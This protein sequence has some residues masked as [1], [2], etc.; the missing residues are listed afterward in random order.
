MFILVIQFS[1]CH[2]QAL[3]WKYFIFYCSFLIVRCT[4]VIERTL[5]KSFVPSHYQWYFTYFRTSFL[6]VKCYQKCFFKL[7]DKNKFKTSGLR[8]TRATRR[9][10]SSIRTSSPPTDSQSTGSTRI[11]TGKKARSFLTKHTYVNR[12]RDLWNVMTI[13][14]W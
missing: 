2:F 11:S 5:K 4:L 8:L 7:I 3:V 9:R 13:S 10:W 1:H 6:I 14:C 12:K